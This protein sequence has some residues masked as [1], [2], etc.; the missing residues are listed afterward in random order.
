[1]YLEG[2]GSL[3]NWLRTNELISVRRV[4]VRS[5]WGWN[6]GLVYLVNL[7]EWLSFLLNH[8]RGLFFG[9]ICDKTT[10]E[11]FFYLL[12]VNIWRIEEKQ[13]CARL[14]KKVFVL[15]SEKLTRLFFEISLVLLFDLGY[16]FG[17][18]LFLYLRFYIAHFLRI[19][20]FFALLVHGCEDILLKGMTHVIK[21]SF[22]GAV[23]VIL[24]GIV[25]PSLKDFCY[26]S[27]FVLELAVHHE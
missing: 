22:H 10:L 1:M 18:I 23:P 14:S 5:L 2:I 20:G 21:L 12:P 9:Q 13:V 17:Q 15:D 6:A 7:D 8:L 19:L 26:L 4:F 25:R 16:Y 3:F 27:P 24:D 11:G